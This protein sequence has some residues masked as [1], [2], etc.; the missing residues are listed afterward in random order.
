MHDLLPW[1]II[2]FIIV[3]LE[4]HLPFLARSQTLSIGLHCKT[5]SRN[6]TRVETVKKAMKAHRTR[7]SLSNWER[8]RRNRHIEILSVASAQKNWHESRKSYF[9]KFL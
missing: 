8:R 2:I 4:K 3:S 7:L 1:V 6:R 9:M 5:I